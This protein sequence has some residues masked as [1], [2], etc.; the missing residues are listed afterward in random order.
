MGIEAEAEA[1]AET[2]SERET[3]IRTEKRIRRKTEADGGVGAGA[4]V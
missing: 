3:I 2:G 4:R 1:G